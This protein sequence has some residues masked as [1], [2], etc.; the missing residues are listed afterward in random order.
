M[1]ENNVYIYAWNTTVSANLSVAP[2]EVMTGL[3]PR[4]RVGIHLHHEKSDNLNITSVRVAT[5][6]YSRVAAANADYNRKR[7]ADHL[8][9][10][11]RKLR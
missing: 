7:N 9:K 4:T 5:A 2:F 8:N 3:T 10:F 1:A 11:G 6:E